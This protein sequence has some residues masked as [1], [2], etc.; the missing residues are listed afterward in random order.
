VSDRHQI[1][2]LLD[3]TQMDIR[4]ASAKLVALRSYVA[5]LD[6][7]EPST[8]T[9]PHCGLKLHGPRSLSTHLHQLHDGPLPDHIAAADALADEPPL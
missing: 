8:V 1:W 5:G 4:A 6:L 9:C 2:E 3:G 7:P